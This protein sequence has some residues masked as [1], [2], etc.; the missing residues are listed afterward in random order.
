[1]ISLLTKTR[2][3]SV[4]RG[5][6]LK[7]LSLATLLLGGCAST[8]PVQWQDVSYPSINVTTTAS[9]GEQLLNQGRGVETD[10]IHV[11]SM[12]G[13]FAT[14]EDETFCRLYPGDDRFYSFNNRAVTFL[15]FIGTVRGR[16]N[17][18]SY[19]PAKNEICVDDFW[20]GCFNGTEA[21]FTYRRNVICSRPNTLQQAIEYNGKS[22][23]TLNF[24]YRETMSG[25]VAFPTTQDFTMDLS[26]G[27]VI[28]YKGARLQVVSATNQQITYR[29]LRNFNR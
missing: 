25:Q 28:N 7:S 23:D 26:L 2:P 15:S 14:I 11:S 22:G 6:C 27:D 19:R 13:K 5:A 12:Q 8:P 20:S 17:D 1:M 21:Q 4:R 10:V 29:V 9:L 3:R 16:G 18:L 24:T